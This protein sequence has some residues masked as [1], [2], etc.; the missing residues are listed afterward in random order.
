MLV[1]PCMLIWILVVP[2]LQLGQPIQ[3]QTPSLR[4]SRLPKNP[5]I[6]PATDPSIGANINGPSL[7]RA[8]KWVKKPLGKYYLYFADH[9]GKYIRLA[10]SDRLDR[11]WKIYKPGTLQLSQSYFTDHIASPDV[12]VDEPHK[13]IRMYYHGLTP[14]ERTQH[15]R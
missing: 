10:Y 15:T 7:I 8:P 6:T 9:N 13:Q 1:N 3:V 4:I 5:I 12:I 14:E 2:R 11:P